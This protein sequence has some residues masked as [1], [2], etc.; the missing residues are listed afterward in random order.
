MTL[1]QSSLNPTWRQRLQA[2]TI[3][4]KRQARRQR[5]AATLK[6]VNKEPRDNYKDGTGMYSLHL[7]GILLGAHWC[8][9]EGLEPWWYPG[10]VDPKGSL[11]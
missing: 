5:V 4:F 9:S 7:R 2:E 1:R 11:N 3:N 10:K 8:V 6:V